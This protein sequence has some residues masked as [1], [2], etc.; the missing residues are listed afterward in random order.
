MPIYAVNDVTLNVI[1]KASEIKYLENDQG[2]ISKT[3]VKSDTE[4]GEVTIEVKL[5]NK[6]K[7][8]SI[9]KYDN[10]EIFI[11]IP[12]YTNAQE[13]EKLT[14]IETLAEKIFAKSSKTKIG[15]I[16]IKGTIQDSFIDENGERVQGEKDQ[17]K[18]NGT[19]KN[20]ECIVD[21]TQNL[22]QL[23]TE[24]RKMNHEKI[25]Y[26]SNLQAA[27]RLANNSFSE[28]SNKIL[29]SLY[30]DVPAISIGTNGQCSYGGLFSQ[31]KTAEEAVRGNLN[32]LV[33]NTRNEILRL[34]ESNIDFILLRPDDTN[35]DKKF[36][37][38][39]TGEVSV[40]IDGKPYADKLYGT[41]E[42]PTY[43]KMYS[44]NNDSL[45]KIV[46]EYIYKDIIEKIR[47]PI[48][49]IKIVDYF[50]NEIISNF[51]F[52]YVSKPNKGTVSEKIDTKDNT[53]IWNIDKLDP[54][55]TATLQYKL[56]IKNMSKNSS[57][58]N[59]EIAT[60][61]KIVLTY[62]DTNQKDYSVTLSSSPKIKLAEIQKPTTTTTQGA[63]TLPKSKDPTVANKILPD[64]GGHI[65]IISSIL[66]AIILI[67][68]GII[69]NHKYKDVK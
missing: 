34:K 1:Q 2:N 19:E 65:L 52:A 35:F 16:G 29:I 51:D 22:T 8:I 69:Q 9:T 64:T 61:E 67:A 23:K 42:K 24:L 39:K 48:S 47:T 7:D 26:Y 63:T 3:I 66:L 41:L 62:K 57:I 40:E 49:N 20:A 55:E 6:P 60:N 11:I 59:K 14:Y 33:N 53:I 36:Y 44:L 18:V 4:K 30:D 5:A 15:I 28:N 21:L 27:L 17:I 68:I 10:S 43:G 50:P 46:T 54:N 37:D 32:E 13:N 45:D 56:K 31:Y 38:N 58:Y 12:E 25:Q